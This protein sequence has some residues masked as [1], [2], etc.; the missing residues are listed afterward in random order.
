MKLFKTLSLVALATALGCADPGVEVETDEENASFGGGGKADHLFSACEK[1]E[2]LKL[3]NESTS[4]ADHLVSLGM[5]R[6]AANNV[7]AHRLGADGQLGTADDDIFDDF[8]EFDDVPYVGTATLGQAVDAIVER[9]HESLHDRPFI[10]RNT[11]SDLTGGGWTRDNQEIEAAMTVSGI[12]GQRLNAILRSTDNR[13]RTIFSRLRRNRDFEGLTYGYPIDEVPWDNGSM[14]VRESLAYVALS[15][16]SGRFEIDQDDEDGERELSVGT[17]IMDDTY[18]DAA[19]FDLLNAE[20]N[21]RGRVRWDDDTTVRRLL[22]AAKF[23][24]EVDEAGLKRAAK[25]DV[26]TEG[27]THVGTLDG[28]VMSGTV[29]WS[30]TRVP[31][32]PIEAVYRRALELELLPHMQGH[33]DVLLMNP[34][35]HMRSERSRYHLNE[36]G[37]DALQRYYANG[38][39]RIE[40]VNA[41]ITARLPDLPAAAQMDAEALLAMGQRILDGTEIEARTGSTP[42][43]VRPDQFATPTSVDEVDAQ[44]AVADAVFDAMHDYALALDDLDNTLAG[45]DDLDTDDEFMDM[46]VL[47]RESLDPGL[48]VKT[49]ARPFVEQH[50]ALTADLDNALAEFNAFGEAQLADGND[51]F[52]DFE[53]VDAAMFADIGA[54][55]RDEDLG[56][57]HR[58]IATA[59]I[60]ARSLW[61]D[62]AR[63]FYVPASTRSAWTNFIID[64]TDFTQMITNEEW[65]SIPEDQRNP[66]T[67]LDPAKVFHSMLV[68]EVQ[69][70]LGSEVPYIERIAALN[71]ELQTNPTDDTERLLA[72]AQFVFDEYRNALTTIAALKGDAIVDRLEDEGGPADMQWG[73]SEASKGTTA[74]RIVAN[75]VNGPTP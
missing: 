72:G 35:V 73:A 57:S 59:G 43:T 41:L 1:S 51:D 17:D 28:D 56:D 24:S 15:I 31:I 36:A 13:G 6:R 54:Y 14:D 64:T 46:F 48:K 33:A 74:L 66:A 49:I 10:D 52:E 42:T 70:E 50:V 19:N 67:D 34:K 37:I 69:I 53:T 58:M 2:V 27:G 22:I 55:L 7:W 60:M 68:N 38:H 71:E 63:Q 61:F 3:L 11:F 39:T 32:Q 44:R 29:P 5:N 65:T 23:G 16:E 9:C 20:I 4:T 62:G 30:G 12:T 40:E 8:D 18:Y 47:W 75:G 45:A 21:V 25:I 26:R